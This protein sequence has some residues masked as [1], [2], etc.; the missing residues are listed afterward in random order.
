MALNPRELPGGGGLECGGEGKT[1]PSLAPEG[2]ALHGEEAGG[3]LSL[4][5]P[6]VGG[7]VAVPAPLAQSI[8]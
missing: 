1:S 8:L 3:V 5:P 7:G 6:Q 4:L 2:L